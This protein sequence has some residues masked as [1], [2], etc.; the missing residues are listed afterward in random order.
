MTGVM[1]GNEAKKFPHPRKWGRKM[2]P[3]LRASRK[4]DIIV[5]G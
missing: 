2:E 3:G 1:L 4:D 5:M